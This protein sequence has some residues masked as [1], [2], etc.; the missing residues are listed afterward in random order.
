MLKVLMEVFFTLE[1]R[2]RVVD[3]SCGCRI[4]W[5]S[6]SSNKLGKEMDS[7]IP[8]NI[9][10]DRSWRYIA[11]GTFSEAQCIHPT[12]TVIGLY[13]NIFTFLIKFPPIVG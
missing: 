5:N 4:I 10:V 9:C 8:D 12:I 13:W 2:Q 6:I 7:T 11:Y 3:N 1:V